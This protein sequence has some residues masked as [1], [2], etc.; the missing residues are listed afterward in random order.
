MTRI[1][2]LRKHILNSGLGITP[3]NLATYIEDGTVTSHPSAENKHFNLS[4]SIK[5]G[6]DHFSTDIPA[7]V[8]MVLLW[9]HDEYPTHS[10]NPIS[11][12][13]EIIDSDSAQVVLTIPMQDT[14][15][16]EELEN[17]MSYTLFTPP[18]LDETCPDTAIQITTQYHPR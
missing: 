16:V 7:L 2:S 5:I 12:E 4:Y 9:L 10:E 3:D 17:G 1:E 14:Y 15:H 6:V 13:T 11:F 8:L 18:R